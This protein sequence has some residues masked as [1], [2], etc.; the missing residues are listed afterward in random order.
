MHDSTASSFL[1]PED[2]S[3]YWSSSDEVE[4]AL[5]NVLSSHAENNT[6]QFADGRHSNSEMLTGLPDSYGLKEYTFDLNLF[7]SGRG[8]MGVK[9][10]EARMAARRADEA[11]L[12][13]LRFCLFTSGSRSNCCCNGGTFSVAYS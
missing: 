10:S 12:H 4:H 5:S 6:L 1:A 9:L 7:G 8:A 2:E 3:P 11:G 13:G